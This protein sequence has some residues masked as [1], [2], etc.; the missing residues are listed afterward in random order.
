MLCAGLGCC[1]P[2]SLILAG[3]G[4]LLAV[5]PALSAQHWAP[6]GEAGPSPAAHK[7]AGVASLPEACASARSLQQVG[8][9]VTGSCYRNAHGGEVEGGVKGVCRARLSCLGRRGASVLVLECFPVSICCNQIRGG[10][11]G[12]C[13]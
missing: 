4:V 13:L 1:G 3:G 2:A 6:R 8:A 11:G 7:G 10:G 5:G 12:R 9:F